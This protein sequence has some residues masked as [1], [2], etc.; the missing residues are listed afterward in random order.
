MK[1]KIILPKIVNDFM[2]VFVKNN[3]EIFVVGGAIRDILLG[4]KVINWDF[5][6]NASPD[7]IQKLFEKTIYNNI[8]GTVMIPFGSVYGEQSRTAPHF[9]KASRGKQGKPKNDIFEV[10]PYRKESEYSDNR[11]PEKIEWTDKI[12]E[13]LARRDFSINALAFDGKKIVDLYEGQNDLQN[14]IIKSVG[15]PDKRFAEDGLRLMRAVRIATQLQF[16]IDENTRASI[17]KNAHLLKNISRERIRDE[18]FKIISSDYPSRGILLL[19]EV[20]LLKYILPEVDIAFTVPQVSPMRHHIYD[21]G[22]H[23]VMALKHCRSSDVIVRLA[24]LLHDVGKVPTFKKDETTQLITFFNHEI[25]GGKMILKI[26]DNLRLSNEQKDKLFKL[27][28][29][30][31]FTVTEIQTDKAVRR[32]INNV[33]KEYLDDVLLVREADRVGSGANLT[34]WRTELFKKRLVEVQ[35]EPF[36]ITDLKI[37]GLDVMKALDIKPGRIIGDILNKTFEAVVD[38]KIKNTKKELINFI[39]K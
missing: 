5:T 26:G 18:L 36:K 10:T 23:M 13:D 39:K 2:A 24:T 7:E 31:Q 34:S 35:K 32:F 16:S 30:H 11:H 19:K 17:I 29:F 6:T 15:E 21:V 37:D 20:G 12:D 3:F 28:R 4:K 38:K 25:E 27:V 9:A 14:K 1:A 8:Y 33:G 22:T